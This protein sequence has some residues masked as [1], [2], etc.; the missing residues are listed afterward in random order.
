M[1]QLR[2][3]TLHIYQEPG[4]SLFALFCHTFEEATNCTRALH[5]S[6]ALEQLEI[7]VYISDSS[8]NPP[9]RAACNDS[10]SL[11]RLLLEDRILSRCET[12]ECVLLESGDRSARLTIILHPPS[13]WTPR[14]VVPR[15]L[16][17]D[18]FPKLHKKGLLDVGF[19]GGVSES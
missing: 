9:D 15:T 4:D 19:V 8:N 2:S 10:V 11:A 5:S 14:E 17:E 13:L 7:H 1:S 12:L 3:L 16:K 18:A 6:S